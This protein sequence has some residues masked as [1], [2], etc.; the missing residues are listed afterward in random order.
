MLRVLLLV[1]SLGIVNELDRPVS[2]AKHP[3]LKLWPK[4][5]CGSG[6]PDRSLVRPLAEPRETEHFRRVYPALAVA[7]GSLCVTLVVLGFW[8]VDGISW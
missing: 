6:I 3:V 5:A 7:W 1:V 8:L 2:A 4:G